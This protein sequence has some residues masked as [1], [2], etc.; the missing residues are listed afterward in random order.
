MGTPEFEALVDPLQLRVDNAL[1]ME[2]PTEENWHGQC[3]PLMT[4]IQRQELGLVDSLGAKPKALPKPNLKDGKKKKASP[5]KA[6]KAMKSKKKAPAKTKKRKLM[7]DNQLKKKLHSAT[8]IHSCA[9]FCLRS[10]ITGGAQH[11]P[12]EVYSN[13]WKSAKTQWPGDNAKWAEHA[14]AKRKEPLGYH[15]SL[16]QISFFLDFL[17][18]TCCHIIIT[19]SFRSVFIASP[20]H[21]ISNY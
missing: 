11:L 16:V 7:D 19:H 1:L 9:R 2:V 6:L 3:Q 20:H 15:R 8:W 5:M 10:R 13:A 21:I 12:L 17:N 14:T 18:L 4:N